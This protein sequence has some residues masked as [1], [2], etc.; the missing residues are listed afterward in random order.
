MTNIPSDQRKN[1]PRI[2]VPSPKA[3]PGDAVDFSHIEI[4]AAGI[5]AKP[6]TDASAKDLFDYSYSLIRVLDD[7]GK[8]VGDWDPKLDKDFLLKGLKHMVKI[9]VF[10]DQII[11]L[12]RTGRMSF[13]VKSS[14]EEAVSVAQTM[15]LRKSD[16]LF[17]TY[18]QQGILLTKGCP[19]VD[20]VCQCLSNSKDNLKGHQLPTLYSWKE[21]SF[22]TVSGNLG[23]QYPQA[24]GWAMASAYKGGDDIAMA[25]V[26]DGT[27]AEG[28]VHYG[29]TFA[30]VYNAPVILN[31]TN[32]QW[33]ISSFQGIAG[34]MNT[35]F[36]SKGIGYGLP[37]LRV[38]GND[39]LAVYSATRWAA[40]R[41]RKGL[42]ATV[43]ELFTY[44]AAGHSTSDDPTK[45][46]PIDEA[47]KWPLGDPI[48]R[49]KD[50][51]IG[52][53]AW[54]EE[55]HEMLLKDYKKEV[56]EAIK[57][58]ESYGTLNTEPK[59]SPALMFEDV[60]EEIPEH[61]IQQRR[62]LGY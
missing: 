49:L 15:A 58:A 32:N 54:S 48:T 41:A 14:G 55:Q 34:G 50:H 52:L 13:Y 10:D 59:L 1:A 35:T 9:R 18:R 4:P 53:G 12:Q 27:T 26:G 8:A 23:T 28:D 44:R 40:E 19:M 42:G 45:Y 51:L 31:I 20:I 43:I 62:E 61:L 60:F 38:D 2:D 5:L 37:G 3:R 39:F 11:S 6:P 30:S 24:V 57:E 16:M 47:E 29:L 21:Y 56:R 17:P 36:A 22:F 25:W 46:R 33:A 7:D